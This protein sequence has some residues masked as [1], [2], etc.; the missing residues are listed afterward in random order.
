VRYDGGH[1]RDPFLV[2]TLGKRVEFVPVCPEAECGLSVPREP[3][4]LAGDP[5]SLH[6]V[7]VR[8]GIDLTAQLTAWAEKRL[9]DLEG[10]YIVGFI[11]KK[12]SPSCAV[13]GVEVFGE[14]GGPPAVGRGIFAG[15][16]MDRF[17]GI[18]VEDEEGLR[19]PRRRER[20]LLRIR[21]AQPD[22][23]G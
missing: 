11:F 3:M 10:E 14:K 15:M 21:P 1:K 6:L 12:G 20:F 4:Q 9:G 16:F 18:P 19:D 13:E 7:T 8:T 5:A 23:G 17:P 2:E 22:S